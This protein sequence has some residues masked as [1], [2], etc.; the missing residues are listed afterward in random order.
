MSDY[1]GGGY[2]PAMATNAA[3]G[4]RR[5]MMAQRLMGGGAPAG[6]GGG[7]YMPMA[8]SGAEGGGA[9]N[10]LAGID[11]AALGKLFN[12]DGKPGEGKVGLFGGGQDGFQSG[13]MGT[14][15]GGQNSSGADAL[16]SMGF[17]NPL[18]Q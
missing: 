18:P 15:I 13:I 4:Q 6:P 7:N 16:Q 1:M 5:Q 8:A 11:P 9:H 3:A 17:Y 2:A 12:G 14:G 10:P